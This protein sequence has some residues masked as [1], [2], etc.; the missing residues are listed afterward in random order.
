MSSGRKMKDNRGM[1]LVELI[2]VI[3]IMGVVIGVTG[4]GLALVSKKP[5]DECAKKIEIALNQT[6]TNAMGS[7]EAY[8]EFFLNDKGRVTVKQH[9]L[10]SS[11]G[12]GSQ[13]HRDSKPTVVG[14]TGVS[15]CLYCM[16]SDT[17]IDLEE[18]I[19][20]DETETNKYDEN[21]ADIR[22]IGFQRDSGSVKGF[23]PD[24]R[25]YTKIVISKGAYVKTIEI[26]PLTG[27]VKLQ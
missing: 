19:Y 9:L 24:N 17:P 1:T 23:D 20:T 7:T 10:N 4:Y 18:F 22:K 27:K 11:R 6:R 13:I 8:V 5:V 12:D 14:A 25:V 15:V 16:G 26:D 3:A 2:I 21:S